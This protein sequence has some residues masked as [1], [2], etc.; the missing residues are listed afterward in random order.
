VCDFNRYDEIDAQYT[1]LL[2]LRSD[3]IADF[4]ESYRELDG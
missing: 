1:G 2:K 4:I 3:R